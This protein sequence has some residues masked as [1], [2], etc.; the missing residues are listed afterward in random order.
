MYRYLTNEAVILMIRVIAESFFLCVSSIS[1]VFQF[2]ASWL[3]LHLWD[4]ENDI[5]TSVLLS[6]VMPVHL[7]YAGTMVGA[8]CRM[9]RPRSL[10]L[11]V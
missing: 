4:S 8:A 1:F 10:H 9:R 2:C 6:V 5:S 3:F 7:V 11:K